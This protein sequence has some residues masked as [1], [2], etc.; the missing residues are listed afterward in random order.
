M[1]YPAPPVA[2]VTPAPSSVQSRVF[3]VFRVLCVC[4]V[5][6]A[7]I[8]ALSA[9]DTRTGQVTGIFRSSATLA[10]LQ[11][12]AGQL[13]PVF[14]PAITAYSASVNNLTDQITVTPTAATTGATITVNGSPVPSGQASQPITLFVGGNNSYD[15]VVTNP[16]GKSTQTYTIN[17]SRSAF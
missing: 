5:F 1:R 8:A 7:S 13:A 9:C 17:V 4:L 16:D 11:L 15:I 10:N 2:P 14:S 6:G 3:R 12:S